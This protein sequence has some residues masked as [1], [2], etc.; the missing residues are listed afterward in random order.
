MPRPKASKT[1]PDSLDVAL[2]N[3][4]ARE[5]VF[6]F[7]EANTLEATQRLLKAEY[8]I[9]RSIAAIGAWAEARRA[10]AKFNGFL[11]KIRTS[12]ERAGEVAQAVG[13][14]SDLTEA[15][16]ALLAQG[17]LDAQLAE[18]PALKKE[19][20]GL[21]FFALGGLAKNKDADAKMLA[22][23]TAHRKFE[24][25][26]AKAALKHAGKLQEIAKSAGSDHEQVG[27]AV[28]LMFG[29]PPAPGE[30]GEE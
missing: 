7:L 30:A 25:D 17:L 8:D 19:A 13:S 21:I 23:K 22:A 6:A 29:K 26:A 27:Q 16:V 18:D 4:E 20:A 5:A 14:V 15:N 12:K 2:G 24:F 3:D 1:R 10:Q 9:E 28:E 11:E